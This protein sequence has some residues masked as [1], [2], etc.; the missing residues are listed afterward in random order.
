MRRV[1]LTPY[2]SPLSGN[3]AEMI[4]RRTFLKGL[5][6]ALWLAGFVAWGSDV[7]GGMYIPWKQAS[8]PAWEGSPLTCC[9]G[10]SSSPARSADS[11]PNEHS[12]HDSPSDADQ[13]AWLGGRSTSGGG[14]SAP[15]RSAGG[16]SSSNLSPAPASQSVEPLSACEFREWRERSPSLPKPPERE[17]L[18]PPKSRA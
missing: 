1:T 11:S 16:G 7:H 8:S 10:S 9:A 5:L 4:N 18:D 14:A 3:R 12:R 2:L 15:F 6:P 13:V 17:L